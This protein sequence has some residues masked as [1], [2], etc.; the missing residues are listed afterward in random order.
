MNAN[1]STISQG[2]ANK[3]IY[4]RNILNGWLNNSAIKRKVGNLK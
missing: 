2:N 1:M 4:F 3:R